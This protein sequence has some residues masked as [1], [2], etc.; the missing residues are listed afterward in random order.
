MA[1]VLN[2]CR[3]ASQGA[4]GAGGQASWVSSDRRDQPMSWKDDQ[5]SEKADN[6]SG[7]WIP[8]CF[9]MFYSVMLVK[10]VG[11]IDVN[12]GE[13]ILFGKYESSKLVA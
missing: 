1:R 7:T 6:R 2:S 8:K 12:V 9:N 11:V 5:G 13:R 10:M 3:N 4:V